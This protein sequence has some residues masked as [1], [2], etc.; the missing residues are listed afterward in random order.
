MPRL[1]IIALE[2]LNTNTYRY[3]FWAD[4]PASRQAF[5]TTGSSSAWKNA[6]A[7]DNAS[8]SAGI[9]VEKVDT[10]QVAPGTGLPAVQIFLQN[11]WAEYQIFVTGYNPWVRYGTTWDGAT[12]SLGGAV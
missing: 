11:K 7:G 2:K 1:R 12:W 8:L 10:L 9:I 5:Y 4:V 3:A 6:L